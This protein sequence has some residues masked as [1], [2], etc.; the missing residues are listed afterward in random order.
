MALKKQTLVDKI[1]VTEHGAIHVR[2]VTRI[3]EGGEVI[4]QAYHRYVLSPGDDISQEDSKTKAV[5][6]AIW[7]AE[8]VSAYQQAN[9]GIAPDHAA[10]L[11]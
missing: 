6:A 3:M 5:C 2:N 1:E 11:N 4:S 7:T 10:A 9:H 8:V